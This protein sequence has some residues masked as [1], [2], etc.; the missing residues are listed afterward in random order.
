[1]PGPTPFMALASTGGR[2]NLASRAP[3]FQECR[4]TDLYLRRWGR[5]N[6]FHRSQMIDN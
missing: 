4:S 6:D 5:S 1:M 2:W 3:A